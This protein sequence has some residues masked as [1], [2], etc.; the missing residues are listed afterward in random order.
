LRNPLSSIAFEV[1]R[2]DLAKEMFSIRSSDSASLS[3]KADKSGQQE[4]GHSSQILA[5]PMIIRNFVE[6]G[7]CLNSKS[8]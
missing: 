7:K 8:Y 5:V 6:T 1:V 4:K 3:Q 2:S